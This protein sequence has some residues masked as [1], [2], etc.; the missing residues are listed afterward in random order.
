MSSGESALSRTLELDRPAMLSP[1]FHL[2][3]RGPG[4]PTHRQI[5]EVMLRATRTPLGPAL[6]KIIARG[7]TI[8]AR[9]WGGMGAGPAAAAGRS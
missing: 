6:L 1:M 8:A 2:L 7:H 4:D 9:A 5:G 3:R